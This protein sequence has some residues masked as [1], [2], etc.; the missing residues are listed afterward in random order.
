MIDLSPITYL[1]RAYANYKRYPSIWVFFLTLIIQVFHFP[2]LRQ[3]NFYW[4]LA[5]FCN[6]DN[7]RLAFAAIWI[8]NAE[9][10]L[11]LPMTLWYVFEMYDLI[12][13]M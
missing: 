12:T 10:R 2:L 3:L 11:D 13:H 6:Q 7:F 8:S 5:H 1:I 4:H 9:P